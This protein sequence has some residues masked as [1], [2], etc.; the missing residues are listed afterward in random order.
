[1]SIQ[2]TFS[3][4]GKLD[5]RSPLQRHTADSL[6]VVEPIYNHWLTANNFRPTEPSSNTTIAIANAGAAIHQMLMSQAGALQNIYAERANPRS[7]SRS[8]E[9]CDHDSGAAE[10]PK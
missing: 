1:V 4:R 3:H 5:G 9:G 7:A 8:G 6:F 10:V 2:D